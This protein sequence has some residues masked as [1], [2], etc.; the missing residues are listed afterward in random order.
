[1]RVIDRSRKGR[2]RQIVPVLGQLLTRY[3]RTTPHQKVGITSNPRQRSQWS[4]Y[5]D[6]DEM[7]LVYRTTSENYARRVEIEL[8]EGW[9]HM[10]DNEQLGGGQLG[11]P[12]HYVYIVRAR[13]S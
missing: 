12:P 9:C 4:G 8:I 2:P 7:V 1:M 5:R 3:S 6:Y 10:L 13:R 11:A